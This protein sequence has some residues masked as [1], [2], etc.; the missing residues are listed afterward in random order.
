MDMA[1]CPAECGTWVN[2]S[3]ASIAFQSD[4]IAENRITRWWRVR[5]P[6]P[7]CKEQML[8]R[9]SEDHELFQGCTKHGYWIDV[10]TV[11]KTS[12]GRPGLLARLKK[13]RDDEE[14]RIAA[15]AQQRADELA[16]K[17]RMREEQERASEEAQKTAEREQ[18]RKEAEKKWKEEEKQRKRA[19][20]RAQDEEKQRQRVQAKL[21]QA[22]ANRRSTELEQQH[23]E[24]RRE[25]LLAAVKTAM[26]A[27]DPAP[28]V[29]EIIS[30]ETLVVELGKR[31]TYLEKHT[32]K[33]ERA[34]GDD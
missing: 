34:K 3:I 1:T 32:V 21:E 16:E 23:L 5:E 27:D 2:A 29:N 17:Q 13:L 24:K 28:I 19:A 6:C 22:E 10:D 11:S 15:R 4:E 8:L 30:L 26:T 12:L 33:F 14:A 18:Q 20:K 7:I 31:V 25:Q 9:G